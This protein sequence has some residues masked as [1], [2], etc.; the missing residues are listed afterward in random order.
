[1]SIHAAFTI[2][3]LRT[4]QIT[5]RAMIS[6]GETLMSA[7]SGEALSLRTSSIVRVA[8]TSFHTVTCGAE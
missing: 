1:M 2:G 3:V 8:S 6:S 7:K 4:A 5:A